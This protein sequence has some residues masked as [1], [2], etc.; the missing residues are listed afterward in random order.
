MFTARRSCDLGLF[1]TF[2]SM[3]HVFVFYRSSFPQKLWELDWHFGEPDK[4]HTLKSST[5][6]PRS[7]LARRGSKW[8]D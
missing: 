5:A 1:H 3:R 8:M 6:R 2:F 4:I 7:R